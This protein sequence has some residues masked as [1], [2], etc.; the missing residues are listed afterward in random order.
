MAG[1][2][3]LSV[4]IGDFHFGNLPA[5]PDKADTVLAVDAD[6]VLMTPIAVQPFQPVA[7]RHQQFIQFQNRAQSLQLFPRH[8]MKLLGT[9]TPGGGAVHAVK[10]VLRPLVG[11]SRNHPA[12]VAGTAGWGQ[13]ATAGSSAQFKPDLPRVHAAVLEQGFGVV[14]H[15]SRTDV[16]LAKEAI[17]Q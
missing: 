4:I 13:P 6:T 8:G 11:K 15:I 16:S 3:W 14:Q 5:I 10:N 7:S 2:E 17:A 12:I 1:K 9:G